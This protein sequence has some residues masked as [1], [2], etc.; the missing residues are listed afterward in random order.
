MLP[1]YQD[2]GRLRGYCLLTFRA[3]AG[4]ENALKLDRAVLDGRYLEISA[5]QKKPVV[6]KAKKT[7]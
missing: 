7:A 3:A 1:R 2:S 6:K 5:A 4:V